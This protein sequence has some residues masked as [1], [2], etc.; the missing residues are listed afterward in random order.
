MLRP[1]ADP[2]QRHEGRDGRRNWTQLH[3]ASPR[4]VAVISSDQRYSFGFRLTPSVAELSSAAQRKLLSV[5]LILS[6]SASR[7]SMSPP[8]LPASRAPSPSHSG[9]PAKRKKLSTSCDAC[10][11]RKSRCEMVTANGCHR[12]RTLNTKCSRAGKAS[13][14]GGSGEVFDDFGT[15]AEGSEGGPAD[16]GSALAEIQGRTRRIEAMLGGLLAQSGGFGRPGPSLTEDLPEVSSTG[17]STHHAASATA[18]RALILNRGNNLADPVSAGI[19]TAAL[20]EAVYSR[21]VPI[22]CYQPETG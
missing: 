15:E 8:S 14:N 16:R 21:Q 22:H 12:C 1:G 20:W 3:R 19:I 10:Q 11:K 7:L 9:N 18:N 4:A 6:H 2:E 13:G 5:T 17:Q